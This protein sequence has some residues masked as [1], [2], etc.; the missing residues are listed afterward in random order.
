[1]NCRE[2]Q[3]ALSLY[4]YGEL[5]FA[6]EE[7]LESHLAQCA[8]CQLSLTREKEWHTV[9]SGQAQEPPFD[10]LAE[11]RQQLRPALAREKAPRASARSWW[12]WGNPFEISTTRGSWQ[13]A[14]AS[15]LV[16]VGFGS[17]RLL[18]HVS[19][20]T[21]GVSQ[22]SVLNPAN[23]LVRDVQADDSGLVRIVVQQ[24]SAIS[25]RLDDPGIRSLLLSATRQPDVGVRFYSLQILNQQSGGPNPANDDLRQVYFDSVRNDPNPAV[26]LVALEGMRR[27]SADPAALETL[28]FVLEHDSDAGVRS[29]AIDVLAP[30]NG[31]SKMTPAMT[32][33]IEDI[34]RATPEDEYVRTRCAQ[35]LEEAKLPLVF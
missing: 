27:F 19:P 24:E 29:Q 28:K 4:L 6:R 20:R 30:L 3:S 13:V 31:G 9:A 14:L 5:D 12:R 16:L 17:A 11:C 26:R 15:M 35:V 23:T 33:T 32:R 8:A 25:G 10:L 22:M 18:D 2:I 21:L 7:D 1:M 34:L